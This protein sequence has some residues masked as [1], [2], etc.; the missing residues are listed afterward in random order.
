MSDGETDLIQPFL[1]DAGAIRGR[2]V[3]LGP[4]I[5]GILAEHGYPDAVAALLA[6]TLALG[7]ALAGS[8]KYD[9]IF[10]LQ[11][12][13]DGAVPLIVADVTSEGAMRGYARFDADRLEKAQASKGPVVPRLLGKG[14]LAFTVDQG[15]D[16]DRYQGIVEL[17][18]DTLAA[19]ARSY[20][21]QSEQL[22]TEVQTAVS[23]ASG[24]TGWRAAALMIQRMPLGPQS[25]IFTADQADES[26]NRATILMA[27]TRPEELLGPAVSV[28]TLL[29]RLYH[30]DGLQLLGPRPLVARCRCQAERVAG[31]LKSFPRDEVEA[32]KDDHGDVVVVCEFCKSRYVFS[33]R[34]LDRLYQA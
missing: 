32:M 12:Q 29:H 30:A 8:L 23:P 19:C 7:A 5:D 9:G 26:W 34:D 10:T 4:A 27:S 18:G 6:E 1:I 3:R 20:F 31:T 16:T 13:G 24:A 21:E 15:P 11:I 14:Y 28:E 25:P 22:Q 33:D 17:T 2:A